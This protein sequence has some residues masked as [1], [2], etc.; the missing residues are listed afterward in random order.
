MEIRPFRPADA[1]ALVALAVGCARTETAFVLNPLWES[2]DELFG[3][4]AR[5]GI[6]PED[7]L[8]VADAGGGAV[9]GLVGFLRRPGAPLAGLYTPIVERRE[10]G[11]G[12]GGELLR[13]GLALGADRLGVKVAA[14]A[15]GTRNKAGY[16][17]LG[18]AGF[19]PVRQHFLMRSDTAPKPMKPSLPGLVLENATPAAAPGV[20]AIYEACGFEARS[21]EETER[22]LGDPRHLVAIAL[23][24]GEVVAFAEL[25]L[26]WP[27]RP[28]VSFVGVAPRQR[29]RGL[30]SALVAA[31]L[32][33]RFAAGAR[34]AL[35]LLSPANRTGVR[36]YE[37][38]GFR[39]HRV[40]DVLEK[41]L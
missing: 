38:A 24:A 2:E 33:Q 19:R 30:G 4:F 1:R 18:G 10:R 17:L 16:S 21:L 8:L 26:H 22:I 39:R 12:L 41:G 29:D 11:H 32:E 35:L 20:H 7:H 14:A 15:I 31:A 28:W 40:V 6:E 36:A 37:K 9:A 27:V 23:S 34:Q 3:D 5:L 25:D 13:A